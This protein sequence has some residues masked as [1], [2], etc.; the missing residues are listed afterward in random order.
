MDTESAKWKG[1]RITGYSF[2][3]GTF[4]NVKGIPV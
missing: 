3:S 1:R 2:R 4:L